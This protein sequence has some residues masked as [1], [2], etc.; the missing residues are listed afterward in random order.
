MG[1][2]TT[3]YDIIYGYRWTIISDQQKV[4]KYGL[5]LFVFNLLYYYRLYGINGYLFIF[6]EGTL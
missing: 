6:L 2:F 4:M 1:L 3:D 5:N